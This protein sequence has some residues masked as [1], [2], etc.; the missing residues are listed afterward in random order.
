MKTTDLCD[1]Y[2]NQITVADPIGFKSFGGRKEFSGRIETVK[3]HE[4]NS[5]V[6]AALEKNGKGKVLVVD[7]GGSL[8]CAL[9]GDNMA[10]LAQKNE[11]NG[12][13]IYGCIR[14]SELVATLDIGV[15]ALG[16]H[17]RKSAKKNEG[18]ANIPVY[19]AG[20][21]F[22]PGQTI[23]IDADGILVSAAELALTE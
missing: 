10:A 1:K 4:D 3:C 5:L 22:D 19:F 11:W 15:L 7:G 23:Y 18:A 20:V 21:I 13:L 6:R 12:V 8:R 16:T 14:D 17:P 9:L 2:E